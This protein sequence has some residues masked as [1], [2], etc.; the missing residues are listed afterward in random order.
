MKPEKQRVELDVGLGRQTEAA[1]P[2]S[3]RPF[4][5]LLVGD[6]GGRRTTD[7]G[8]RGA[9]AFDR[10]DVDAAIARIGPVLTLTGAGGAT[11][12]LRFRELEDFHPDRLFDSVPHFQS[13]RELREQL[14][15]ARTFASAARELAG[16]A[17]GGGSAPERG[18]T[19]EGGGR[20]PEGGTT[21]GGG[22]TATAAALAGGSLL[23]R[24]LEGSPP[25][26]GA[27]PARQE[28]DLAAFVRQVVAPHLA[29]REDPRQAEMVAGVDAALAT[30]MRAL[31]HAPSFQRLEAAWRTA[32]FLA[33]RIE[34]DSRLRLYLLD[35]PRAALN[36]ALDS[37]GGGVGLARL[38][39]E[40][41]G[42]VPD[43]GGWTVVAGLY[44]FEAD[45][46]DALRVAQLGAIARRLGAAFVA[47]AAPSFAGRAAW[48]DLPD[49]R[50]WAAPAGGT[51]AAIR[52]TAEASSVA[53]AAPRFLLRAPYGADGEPTEAFAF[54][55]IDGS[56][57][58]DDFLW[59]SGGALCALLL[60][61]G[62]AAD[63]WSLRANAGEVRGLPLH[64]YRRDGQAIA[65]PCA[66][67]LLTERAADR[68]MELGVTPLA[69]LR[70]SD[71]VRVVR[72]QSI[73]APPTRL[74]GAW[75]AGR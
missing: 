25:P 65:L 15:D 36:A 19:T 73:A 70:D 33:R 5:V 68:M 75:S 26:A 66:E 60:A 10:D 6:F 38:L 52:G 74:A 57:A 13:L 27:P 71:T 56:P 24:M 64:V 9:V 18:G 29:E 48:A 4:T 42:A 59:G 41:A 2:A 43:G 47:G 34:T 1:T 49:P 28:D 61:Q 50:E 31:L 12:E 46:A 7:L 62:F 22:T 3:D 58:H 14:S 35:L 53:L 54:E 8:G 40:A 72:L 16:R 67:T 44:D 55:E 37:E 21:G 51:W 63:G 11:F 69:S 30:Q 32:D 20:T 45:D 17:G 39:A 23:D